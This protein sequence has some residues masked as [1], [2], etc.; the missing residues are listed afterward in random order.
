MRCG[1]LLSRTSRDVSAQF[2]F[3]STAQSSAERRAVEI[4]DASQP[5]VAGLHQPAARLLGRLGQASRRCAA[6]AFCSDVN[7]RLHRFD[8]RRHGRFGIRTHRNVD[9]LVALEVLVVRPDVQILRG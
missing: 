2:S 8:Q 6:L 4:G 1:Q 3:L 5:A 9:R 7:A